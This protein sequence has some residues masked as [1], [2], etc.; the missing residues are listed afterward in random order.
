MKFATIK[1]PCLVQFTYPQYT[2]DL[3]EEGGVL[4]VRMTTSDDE[5]AKEVLERLARILDDKLNL[6]DIGDQD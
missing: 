6:T 3:E 2:P 1:I 5:T 4:E